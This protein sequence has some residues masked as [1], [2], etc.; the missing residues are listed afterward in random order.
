MRVEELPF[1]VNPLVELWEYIDTICSIPLTN[2]HIE[3]IANIFNKGGVYPETQAEVVTLIELFNSFS[4]LTEFIIED[5]YHY[6]RK[7]DGK[8][9]QQA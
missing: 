7:T 6:I 9:M 1:P 2:K 8:D 3:N 4:G 5:S